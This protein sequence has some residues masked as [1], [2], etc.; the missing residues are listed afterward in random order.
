MFQIVVGGWL[1]CTFGNSN[2]PLQLVTT[3]LN[4]KWYVKLKKGD[5]VAWRKG[6]SEGLKI[7]GREVGYKV[8][9]KHLG[10]RG[11]VGGEKKG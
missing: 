3:E 5:F 6:M 9:S 7:W 8:G 2:L 11:G 1:R 4:S 10:G